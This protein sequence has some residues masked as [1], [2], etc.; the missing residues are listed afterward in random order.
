VTKIGKP[1]VVFQPAT[2]Q[3]LQNGIEQIVNVISPTLGPRPRSVVL[4]RAFR[5]KMPE[6]LDD[7]GTI[8]RRII[9]IQD[10]DA[11]AGAMFLRQVLWNVREYVGDGT[12]TTAVLFGSIFQQGLRYIASG[13]NAMR[14]HHYLEKGLRVILSD[15][16]AMTQVIGG[17]QNLTH[18]ARTICYE[19]ELA[20]I[21]GEIMDIVGEYGGAE[22]AIDYGRGYR[23]EFIEGSFWPNSI[24]GNEYS[25]EPGANKRI[26][27]EP[28]ILIS[29]LEVEDPQVL[30]PLVE[31]CVRAGERKLVLIASKYSESVISL[32]QAVNRDPAKFQLLAVK[33]PGVAND[34]QAYHMEDMAVLT[35]GIPYIK[36]AG[37]SLA[38]CKPDHFGRARQAWANKEY[39]GIIHGKGDALN[40]RSHIAR[41][42]KAY[43]ASKDNEER[44]R[45][46]KRLAK[47]WN[48]SAALYVGGVNENE[49]NQRKELA[50]RTIDALRGALREG[51]LPGGGVA[52]LACKPALIARLSVES[53]PEEYAAYRILS[54]AMET[55]I[56]TLLT[57]A[58][59][60]AS[61]VMAELK[62]APP[63]SGFD[64]NS[65][66]AVNVIE[67]GIL[68]VAAVTKA[69]VRAAVSGAGLALTTDVIVHHKKLE[70]STKP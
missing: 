50:E 22:L 66:K 40:R 58:G 68:D 10:R 21:L 56:R 16:D 52:F 42:Q 33:T 70:G 43:G 2:Y 69:A 26:L 60:D 64:V 7:G 61:E 15:L 37:H 54:K 31:T 39:F 67:A 45:F 51:V 47:F 6:F 57:N 18:I 5:D 9:Q 4:E 53:E 46:Q 23:K 25:S 28:A 19:P 49:T 14:L 29:N 30:I 62:S 24:V 27:D 63:G 35:G 17:K 55:P 20:G 11:D 38:H 59:Y 48:G 1:G 3:G 32:M 8:A 65:G 41:L 12:A 36:V 34:D 44:K 13:G